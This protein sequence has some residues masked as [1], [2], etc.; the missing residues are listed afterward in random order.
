MV[1]AEPDFALNQLQARRLWLQ[2]IE[3]FKLLAAEEAG[4]KI[5]HWAGSERLAA[6][7]SKLAEAPIP[8]PIEEPITIEELVSVLASSLEWAAAN[9]PPLD[10]SHSPLEP[11][12]GPRAALLE[13]MSLATQVVRFL[14]VEGLVSV[15][16]SGDQHS[17]T[18]EGY[19][20]SDEFF[21]RV[22]EGMRNG[23]NPVHYSTCRML[24]IPPE[25][26]D[27]LRPIYGDWGPMDNQPKSIVTTKSET[28]PNISKSRG[29]PEKK[30]EKIDAIR[31]ARN[32]LARE[33]IAAPSTL[34]AKIKDEGSVDLG[35]TALIDLI[36][37]SPELMEQLNANAD[38]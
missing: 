20:T 6:G 14:I 30:A 2:C 5:T 33:R 16:I 9:G 31:A 23:A 13:S 11:T 18:I 32:I 29:R 34:A 36:N 26:E 22:V 4:A 10:G 15:E 17:T 3:G 38:D 7:L 25:L 12:V 21:E 27:I 24:K 8:L 1:K 37:Q 35:R 28:E 19:S